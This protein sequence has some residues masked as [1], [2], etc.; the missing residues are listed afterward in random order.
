VLYLSGW[1]AGGDPGAAIEVEAFDSVIKELDRNSNGKLEKPEL[2]NGPMAERFSQVDVDKDGSV[3][4]A[5]YEHFRGLFQKGRNLVMAVRP[6]A[7]GEA[8]ES[9][10]VWTNNKQVP[11][12]ASPLFHG[13]IIYVLK[14]GGLFGSLDGRDGKVL[15]YE[16]LPNSGN[17]YSSPVIGDGKIYCLNE[18]GRLTVVKAGRAWE[19]LS[20]SD[21]GEDVYAT[22]AIVDGRIYLRTTGYLYCFGMKAKE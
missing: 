17:Y 20:T 18:R 19:V 14:D 7:R 12:C 4:R 1:A 5:E 11:F 8:T 15:K 3:T 10:V 13:G 2:T 22:P 21:F 9:H 16:R 6:G